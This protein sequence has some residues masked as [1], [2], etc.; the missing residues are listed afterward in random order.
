[1]P[2]D[3]RARGKEFPVTLIGG[4]IQNMQLF[5]EEAFGPVI[6]VMGLEDNDFEQHALKMANS[7]LSGDLAASIF[8]F[9]HESE[10]TRRIIG[11]LKHGIVTVNAYPGIAFA[12]SFPW[13]AGPA[14]LSGRGWIHNYQRL[15]EETLRKVVLTAPLGRK[16]FGPLR[17]EDPWLLNVWGRPSL[18]FARALV[19]LT[20]AYFKGQYHRLPIAQMRLMCALASR[21]ILARQQDQRRVH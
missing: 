1:M 8:T 5:R 12:V 13:G 11:N 7:E 16:G 4:V 2:A 10:Q 14:G 9:K 6:G 17:W 19:Q 20:C 3:P 21:E 15:P 18:N